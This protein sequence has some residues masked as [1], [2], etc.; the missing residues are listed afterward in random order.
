MRFQVG[1][2]VRLSKDSKCEANP[3][4]VE[5]NIISIDN[6]PDLPIDVYW[7]NDTGSCYREID[8]KLVKR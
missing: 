7:R 3:K 4:R 8:L 5:G 1:D 6:D 2:T